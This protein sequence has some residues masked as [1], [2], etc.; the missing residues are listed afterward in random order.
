MMTRNQFP[1]QLLAACLLTVV[2]LPY[3][4][5]ATCPMMSRDMEMQHMVEHDMAT[6]ADHEDCDD[7]SESMD[8][9]APSMTPA[10]IGEAYLP[11]LPTQTWPANSCGQSLHT[12]QPDS[13]TPPPQV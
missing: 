3:V 9:C 10:V 13:T 7:C 2:A 12:S 6:A 4:R 1:I 8:C 5:P 11:D